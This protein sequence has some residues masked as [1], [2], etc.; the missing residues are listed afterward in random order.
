VKLYTNLELQVTQSGNVDDEPGSRKLHQII[1]DEF[2]ARPAEAQCSRTAH[3]VA[4]SGRAFERPGS[5]RDHHGEDRRHGF[6]ASKRLVFESEPGV[7]ISA[8]LYLPGGAGRKP[9]GSDVRRENACPVAAVCSA[10]PVNA[11]AMAEALGAIRGRIVMEV[12]PRD[13]TDA[14]DGRPF[15]GK[16]AHERNAPELVGR[17]LAA[18]AG[19]TTCS[20]PWTCSPRDPDVDAGSIHGYA[21]GVKGVWLLLAAAVDSAPSAR[22]GSTARRGA[23]PPRS[24]LR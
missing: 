23:S 6:C 3:G 14:N 18:M 16:L 13:S 9:A 21:R 11:R 15:L 22:S 8:R 10:E 19:R 12:D 24:K 5:L 2:R 4:A 20:P 17:N 7:P 1:A